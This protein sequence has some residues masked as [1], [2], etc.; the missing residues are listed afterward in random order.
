MVARPQNRQEYARH[1][2]VWK[3]GLR[4]HALRKAKAI[5]GR[6]TD[7]GIAGGKRIQARKQDQQLQDAKKGAEFPGGP[8]I[9]A[10]LHRCISLKKR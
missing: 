8:G 4:Q 1:Q 7:H 10:L 6:V 3:G 2:V 5:S 9:G